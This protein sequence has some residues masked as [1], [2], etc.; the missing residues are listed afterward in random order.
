[1]MLKARPASAPLQQQQQQQR[2]TRPSRLLR[3]PPSALFGGLFGGKKDGES[4][5]GKS[6]RDLDKEEQYRVQMELLE[7]RRSGS[8]IKQASERRQKVAET[9]ADRKNKRAEEKE[10]LGRGEIPKSL[11]DWRNYK[12]EE[13]ARADGK[14]SGGIVLP[15]N[16]LGMREFDE[17]ERF[18]LKSPYSDGAYV[19]DDEV[20]AWD[21]I[22]NFGKKALNFRGREG[23]EEINSKYGKPIKWVKP[24][25]K[26]K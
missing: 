6:Q 2:P 5:G 12:N 26:K 11:L 1:M 14:S 3:R 9:L 21:S 15:L 23:A 22:K 24:L 13:D 25:D 19:D 4:G 18:D 7:A 17:G 20:T 10:A 16:P 8:F